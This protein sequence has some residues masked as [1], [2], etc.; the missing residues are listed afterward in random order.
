MNFKTTLLLILVL[1][2]AGVALTVAMKGPTPDKPAADAS[3][4]AT[5]RNPAAGT[6][7]PKVFDV[8]TTDL[9]KVA[10]TPAN[11]PPFTVV[12]SGGT[13]RLTAPVDAAA[14]SFEVDSLLR[15]LTDARS[16]GQIDPATDP[17]ATGLDV[18][19]YKVELT[20]A[21]GKTMSMDVGDRSGVGGN[22]Y[23]RVAGRPKADLVGSALADQLDRGAD[24]YRNKQLVAVPADQFRRL[25]VTRPNRPPVEL[26]KVGT[27]WTI[28]APTAMP[29]D[30]SAAMELAYAV[31]GLRADSFVD[32][33][34]L[35]PGAID[36]PQV[37]VAFST[38][39]PPANATPT[40]GTATTGPS[41][42]GP[43]TTPA[44]WTTVAVGSYDDILKRN[45]YVSVLGTGVVA[46]VPAAIVDSLGKSPLDLRDKAVVD[47]DPAQVTKV[48]IT[49]GGPSTSQPAVPTILERRKAAPAVLGPMPTTGPTTGPA[50]TRATTKPTTAPAGPATEWVISTDKSADGDDAKVA[51]LLAQFHPLRADK[52]RDPTPP[53]TAPYKRRITV[54]LT[55]KAGGPPVAV[56]MVDPGS[57]GP[58]VGTYN[59]LTFELPATLA[60]DLTGDF[61]K[62][63]TPALPSMPAGMPP[64]MFGR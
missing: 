35:P 41:T 20:T 63:A 32:A 8:A 10:V 47:V 64:G 21:T 23:V 3:A 31:A 34:R 55:T 14:D 46:K 52:L 42:T 29:A 27:A 38:D 17:K 1:V 28:T 37:T 4:T 25:K 11:G 50:T 51:A 30:D 40:G 2:G 59:G 56:T 36:R 62:G 12:K 19:R 57:D 13:W 61:H 24:P 44:D 53:T 43:S 16:R 58:L 33:K 15:A 39:A 7:G 49:V 48:L 26:A 6:D 60:A 5:D 54:E 45:V 18:P 9:V 22:L